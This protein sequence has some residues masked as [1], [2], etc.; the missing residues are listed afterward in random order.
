MRGG[1]PMALGVSAA[2]PM[3]SFVHAKTTS[4][5]NLEHLESRKTAVLVDSVINTGKPVEEFVN[6]IRKFDLKASLIVVAAVVQANAVSEG[7]SLSTL[8]QKGDLRVV[9]LRISDN[10]FNGSRTT[11]TGNRLSNTT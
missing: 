10:R 3:A 6:H 1:E 8:S 11:D 5:L 2:I 7:G 9:G 4:D